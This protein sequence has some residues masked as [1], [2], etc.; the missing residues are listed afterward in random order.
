MEKNDYLKNKD[1]IFSKTRQYFVRVIKEKKVYPNYMQA[2]NK[3]MKEYLEHKGIHDY[4]N[5]YSQC[6]ETIYK[7]AVDE[8]KHHP[9]QTPYELI[10]SYINCLLRNICEGRMGINPRILGTYGQDIFDATCYALFPN[11]YAKDME[12]ME[13]LQT[14]NGVDLKTF[15]MQFYINDVKHHGARMSFEEFLQKHHDTLEREFMNYKNMMSS[16]S[17]NEPTFIKDMEDNGFEPWDDNQDEDDW[18]DGMPWED[19]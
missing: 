9:R 14:Q 12:T 4:N 13:E 5:A 7:H 11:D 15:A 8:F 1:E 3:W 2:M 17:S 16:M 6:F 18:D 19:D 10:T